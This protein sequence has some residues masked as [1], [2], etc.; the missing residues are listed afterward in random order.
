MVRRWA[1]I[2]VPIWA[3]GLAACGTTPVGGGSVAT[4][5]GQDATGGDAT[6]AAS[7]AT[8]TEDAGTDAQP[9]PDVPSDTA[10]DTP[11][12][13]E[14][15]PLGDAP[16]VAELPPDVAPD[17]PPELPDTT[18]LPDLTPELPK[19]AAPDVPPDL[20]PELAPDVV[21]DV[22]PDVL[23]TCGKTK[24]VA[25]LL[26]CGEGPV[27]YQLDNVT[28]TYSFGQGFF[29]YDGSTTRGIQFYAANGWPFD[30]PKV[31]D[32]VSVHVSKYGNFGGQQE[33]LAAEGLKVTGTADASK[34]A[35]DLATVP[36]TM[37]GEEY[38]S[39]LLVGKGLILKQLT[40]PDGLVQTPN[41]GDVMLRLDGGPTNL[42][43]GAVFALK[44]A[45][46]TQYGSSHR[47]HVM[48]GAAD[49]D[50]VDTSNCKAAPLYDMSNWGF[51][52]PDDTDPPPDFLKVGAGFTAQRTTQQKHGGQASCKLTWTST[53]NQDL[54][55]GHYFPIQPGQKASL[56]VWLL[57][58]DPTGRARLGLTFYKADKTMAGGSQFSATYTADN[59]AWAQYTYS[60]TA[61]AEAAFVRGFVRLYDHTGWTGSATVHTDDWTMTA[62]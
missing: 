48:N 42:C 21:K 23:D 45:V 16:V 47:I 27:D 57:D 25:G 14:L 6:A 34:S 11:D 37:I 46:L 17:V 49:L 52:E 38:E 33:V 9:Q 12:V 30:K 24:N 5:A 28:V 8:P 61:P 3:F 2:V 56:A 1:G 31:G 60:Y 51:E 41:A 58:N 29:V 19:D 15:P 59:A 18:D 40:G 54:V 53:D 7:D 43:A 32:V 4:P 35:L 22:P 39:R 13:A 20:P 10:V 55:A 26:L 62:P 44:S 36:K 50:A